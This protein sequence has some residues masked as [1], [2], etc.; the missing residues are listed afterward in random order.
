MAREEVERSL[1]FMLKVVVADATGDAS[2]VATAAEE[3]ATAEEAEVDVRV[4]ASVGRK[5]ILRKI[6]H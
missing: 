5:P 4:V 1:H 3:V 6:I 2:F